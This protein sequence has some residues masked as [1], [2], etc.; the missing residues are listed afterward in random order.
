M[1]PALLGVKKSFTATSDHKEI[2]NVCSGSYKG[3][4]NSIHNTFE[5]HSLFER[6]PAN[7]RN[8]LGKAVQVKYRF[9]GGLPRNL[10]QQ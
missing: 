4:S 1:A 2:E 10:K 3:H 5:R 6:Y 8:D 7:S 9:L